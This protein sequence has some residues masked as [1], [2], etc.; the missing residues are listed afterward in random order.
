ME[1]KRKKRGRKKKRKKRK[2]QIQIRKICAT[3][4]WWFQTILISLL[5]NTQPTKKIP[6]KR[7]ENQERIEKKNQEEK[8]QKNSRKNQIKSQMHFLHLTLPRHINNPPNM[9]L[10]PNQLFR[11]VHQPIKSGYNPK[12]RRDSNAKISVSKVIQIQI[13]SRSKSTKHFQITKKK[14][15]LQILFILQRLNRQRTR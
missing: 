4:R 14:S 5:H 2:I 15:L 10:L 12:R 9:I 6:E 13:Q 7:G 11:S 8:I 1:K 3:E